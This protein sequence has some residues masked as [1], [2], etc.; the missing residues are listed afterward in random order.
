MHSGSRSEVGKH[1][2]VGRSIRSNG[3][4][5][6][7]DKAVWEDRVAGSGNERSAVGHMLTEDFL[8]A[9]GESLLRYPLD[10]S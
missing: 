5:P 3:G 1:C 2:G 6:E 10:S 4:T 8:M 9:A 7:G